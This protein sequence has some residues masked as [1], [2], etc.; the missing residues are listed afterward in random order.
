M[1]SLVES[2]ALANS[3]PEGCPIARAAR[4]ARDDIKLLAAID[5][6]TAARYRRQLRDAMALRNESRIRSAG[7]N[8]WYAMRT[9]HAPGS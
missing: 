8:A 5:P 2:M 1:R 6:E 9:K 7:I 4:G 3:S